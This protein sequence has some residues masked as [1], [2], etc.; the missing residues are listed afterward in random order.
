MDRGTKT[1]LWILG[2]LVLAGILYLV[3]RQGYLAQ[4]GFGS[5]KITEEGEDSLCNDTGND[6]NGRSGL[7]TS[8]CFPPVAPHL[9]LVF[10]GGPK[11]NVREKE[12]LAKDVQPIKNILDDYTPDWNNP[13]KIITKD[14]YGRDITWTFNQKRV[15][16]NTGTEYYLFVDNASYRNYSDYPTS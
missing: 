1:V 11:G 7:K 5:L 6:P 13:T 3:Y 2:I 15:D 10:Q 4:Y 9:Y 12:W 14:K 8:G 16:P